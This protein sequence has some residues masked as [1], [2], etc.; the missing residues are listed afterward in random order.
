MQFIPQWV[1]DAT[2]NDI[3]VQIALPPGVTV[4]D[5]KT[6]QNFYNATSTVE[7]RLA[8]YWEKPSLQPNEQFLIGV[9][10]PAQYLPNYTPPTEGGG[11]D[12]FL[13]QL[14]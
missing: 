7:D 6:N 4:N 5:V 3:R 10:F 9:S 14:L 8:V 1:S 12:A 13:T 2:I 11:F